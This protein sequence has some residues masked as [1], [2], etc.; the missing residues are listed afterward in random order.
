MEISYPEEEVEIPLDSNENLLMPE[1]YYDNIR[2]S[3]DFKVRDY[4]SPTAKVLKDKIAKHHGV[5]EEQI[6]VGNGSD[7]ILDTIT[8]CFTDEKK[9]LGYFHP[10]YEMYPFF[11]SRN[12]RR[13][14]EIPLNADFSMPSPHEY[15]EELDTLIICSP[16]NPS[17]LSVGSDKIKSIL[18]EDLF[19][20][21][22][23]AYA[24]YSDQDFMPL[25]K[26]H[27]NL[28]LVRTFSKAWGLAGI[29]V[30]YAMSS[31]KRGIELLEDMLPYNVNS[32]SIEAA[33]AAL[34]NEDIMKD[35]VNKTIQE[36]NQL[37]MELEGR[38]FN[39]LPS[40]ANFILC[41]T[42]SSIDPKELYE[43]LLERGIR[44]RTFEEPRL[45]DHVRITVG[46]RD[47]NDRLLRDIDELI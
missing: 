10:S 11:A 4:P 8:K 40:E 29:R 27:E 38:S 22:D 12:R 33:L 3:I 41:K 20:V 44:I 37:S 47:I 13:S 16:N 28:I 14:L 2:E 15:L 32:L 1:R 25:L 21:I 46:D 26:D 6:V 19:I 34:D 9:A 7:A 5:N 23:E 43:G 35:S 42:P 30:G 31:S 17:G 24:E 36:K 39:P 18:K 45:K